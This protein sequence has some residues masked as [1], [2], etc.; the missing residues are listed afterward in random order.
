M[1][2]THSANVLFLPVVCV[3]SLFKVLYYW[4]SLRLGWVF[5][6]DGASMLVHI[7]AGWIAFLLKFFLYISSYKTNTN[8][9][10]Y[11]F[12][13]VYSTFYSNY[14]NF[15]INLSITRSFIIGLSVK[16]HTILCISC[17]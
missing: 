11:S 5:F 2:C 15:L 17:P 3:L 9:I 10:L 6:V 16:A 4:Y 12:Q 13:H 14:F 8:T 1:A 7:S